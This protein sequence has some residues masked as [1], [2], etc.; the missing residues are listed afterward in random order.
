MKRTRQSILAQIDDYYVFETDRTI[1]GCVAIHTYP[2]QQVGEMACLFVSSN[3][4]NQGIG[5]KLMRFLDTLAREKGLKALFAL[6]TQAFNY[7]SQKGG[8]K[9][10][11]SDYL[12]AIRREKFDQSGRNSKILWKEIQP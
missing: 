8:F 3:N 12:P 5:G 10:V 6:S 11:P 9:E 2:E 4:E 1:V 7:F